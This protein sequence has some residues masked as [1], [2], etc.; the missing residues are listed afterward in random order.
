MATP[1]QFP[2]MDEVL[3]FLQ[4]QAVKQAPRTPVPNISAVPG[5]PMTSSAPL[6]SGASV[7]GTEI[8]S[9]AES[10]VSGLGRNVPAPK[11]PNITAGPGGVFK[12][13]E[14]SGGALIRSLGGKVLSA[15]PAITLPIPGTSDSLAGHA[16]NAGQ[17]LAS[18]ATNTTKYGDQRVAND[19]ERGRRLASDQRY[20]QMGLP[21]MTEQ[22]PLSLTSVGL[23]SPATA[24]VSATQSPVIDKTPSQAS[25]SAK[26]AGIPESETPPDYAEVDQ[27]APASKAEVLPPHIG[28]PNA[29]VIPDVEPDADVDETTTTG[30][31]ASPQTES[32][33]IMAEIQRTLS[34]PPVVAPVNE[35]TPQ[36]E[37]VIADVTKP[38]TQAPETFGHKV[39]R[40]LVAGSGDLNFNRIDE[41]E[42][43]AR[44]A[45]NALSDKEKLK[46]GLASS[47]IEGAQRFNRES[48]MER[49]RTGG[50]NERSKMAIGALLDQAKM[51]GMSDKLIQQMQLEHQNRLAEIEATGKQKVLENA[52]NAAM[53]RL[54]PEMQVAQTR[55]KIQ[56]SHPELI[57][58]DQLEA[59]LGHPISDEGHKALLQSLQKNGM[60]VMLAEVLRPRFEAMAKQQ[61]QKPNLVLNSLQTPAAQPVKK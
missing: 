48:Q 21:D 29:E 31:S 33:Q 8:P 13:A 53:Q 28:D 26:L 40:F 51:A 38:T 1:Q 5:T 34:A 52:S 7:P 12:M 37:K 42:A 59:M 46:A 60:E 35:K 4:D 17:G 55:Q 49:E 15:L 43:Q 57:P 47:D 22:K 19:S 20:S 45:Q 10:P 56:E 39:K 32:Q 16:W 9:L 14:G 30:A 25:I 36:S 41:Q 24:Q 44:L 58:K 50:M 6:Y 3:K 18:L 11:A 61:Q 2:G 23:G 54:T 27:I